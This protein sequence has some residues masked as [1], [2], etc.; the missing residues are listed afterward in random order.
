MLIGVGHA[1]C[2]DDA[3]IIE[4]VLKETTSDTQRLSMAEIGT[5]LGA[6]GGPGTLVIATQP[7]VNPSS[8]AE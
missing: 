5:A 1:M 7:Y 4:A 3:A 8:L 2:P 6:H